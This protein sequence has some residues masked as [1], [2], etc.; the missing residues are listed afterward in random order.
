VGR[1][2]FLTVFVALLPGVATER[3][4]FAPDQGPNEKRPRGARAA[5]GFVEHTVV[6]AE[7]KRSKAAGTSPRAQNSTKRTL[8]CFADGV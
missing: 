6:L 2:G 4:R 8:L 7:R 3:H 5:A 1:R